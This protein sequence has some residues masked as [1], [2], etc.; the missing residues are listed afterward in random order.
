MP[1]LDPPPQEEASSSSASPLPTTL[2]FPP[3]TKSHILACSYPSWYSLFRPH[4][5]KARVIP[6]PATFTSYLRSDGIVLPPS[7]PG[8]P[9]AST[10]D[11]EGFFSS[12]ALSSASDSDDEAADP[13]A[14]W[15][16]THAAIRA[17]LQD[18]GGAAVPKLNW[19]C[20][21]DATWISATNSLECRTAND[22]YL[23]LKSSDFVTHDLEHAFDEC[24]DFAPPQEGQDIGTVLEQDI[25]YALVLR[26]HFRLNPALEFRVFVRRG[27]VLGMGQRDLNH[28]DFLFGLRP[29]LKERILEFWRTE[30][31]GK[32]SEESYAMDVYVPPPHDRVWVVDFNPW[33]VRTD[34]GLWSWLELLTME[35]P[36]EEE[37]GVEEVVV[38]LR[39]GSAEEVG[40]GKEQEVE[41]VSHLEDDEEGEEAEE[42]VAGLADTPGPEFRLVMRDDPEAYMFNSTRYSAHKL[43]RDVVDA[44]Q[45][46][47][48]GMREFA[49]RWKEML[50]KQS[51]EANARES[52]G[53]DDD[54]DE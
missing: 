1:S 4:T 7:R 14:S 25:D 33:A 24:V 29:K 38:R 26:K 54:D 18:L 46:G 19:S 47:A 13:S 42:T 2:P 53:D 11:D 20:P 27:K 5:P 45:A 39:I 31:R 6:L 43:P 8:T 35:D 48:G 22:V 21:K 51:R 32:F 3:L 23:L 28:Y 30:V 9:R 16:E 50:E 44:S 36:E 17:T 52:D 15:P 49:D 37:E 34:P 10:S 40:N 12:S 41:E